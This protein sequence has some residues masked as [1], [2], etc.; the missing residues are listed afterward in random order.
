MP[1]LKIVVTDTSFPDT[2]METKVL[3]ALN[4]DVIVGRCRTEDEVLALAHDADALMVQWAPIT[5]RVI[6]QLKRCRIIS[7]YGVGVDMIDLDAARDH[8]ITVTNVPDFCLEEVAAQTLSFLLSLSRKD[9]AQDRLMRE[10]GWSVV[11]SIRPLHRL[12][13]QTLGLVGVGRIGR[14][15]AEVAAPLGMCILGYDIAPPKNLPQISCMDLDAVLRESDFVSLHCPLIRETRHLIN[16]AALAKMKPSA[17][18]I[19]VSRGGVLDTQ[20]LVDALTRGQIAG[21][22]LDVFE[23]EPLPASHP[24]R[25]LGNVVLTPHTAAYSEES[26]AQLRRDTAQHVVDFFMNTLKEKLV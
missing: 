6:E 2:E 13:G 19:N 16:A 10:G 22:A 7:R 5:R 17:F 20:A 14:R 18:L 25:K 11:E 4:A 1:Q 15:V 8:G 24:L 9:F 21:A 26:S 3:A 23:E 12:K